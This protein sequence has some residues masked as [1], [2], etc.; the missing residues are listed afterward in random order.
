[1]CVRVLDVCLGRKG[2]CSVHMCVCMMFTVVG[3]V[4]C[5]S[6]HQ[7]T[8]CVHVR[9]I[10]ISF[11]THHHFMRTSELGQHTIQSV[12]IYEPCNLNTLMLGL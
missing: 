8:L 7:A 9:T 2:R 11:L 3:K 6:V 5:A 1:M 4:V 10:G 12:C